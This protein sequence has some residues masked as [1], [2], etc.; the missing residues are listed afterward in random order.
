MNKNIAKR[1]KY[2]QPI[3]RDLSGMGH[4][5]GRCMAGSVAEPW[6]LTDC[7]NGGSA[8][9]GVCHSGDAVSGC[10]PGM[11]VTNWCTTGGSAS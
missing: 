3:A 9:G 7:G 8:D 10:L 4:A 1:K 2:V 6:G 11:L 5:A